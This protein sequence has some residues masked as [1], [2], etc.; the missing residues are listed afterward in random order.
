[1]RSMPCLS[2]RAACLASQALSV[3]TPQAAPSPGG[4][5]CITPPHPQC[6]TPAGTLSPRQQHSSLLPPPEPPHSR[7]FMLTSYFNT[8]ELLGIRIVQATS[9]SLGDPLSLLANCS[10]R[11]ALKNPG[12][13]ATRLLT[14]T[15][16]GHHI[17]SCGRMP[18]W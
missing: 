3:C 12:S 14:R 17:Q 16:V 15:P 8:Q 2:H 11:Q 7:P 18:T 4:P 5:R 6:S 13:E 10:P 1:M 9:V